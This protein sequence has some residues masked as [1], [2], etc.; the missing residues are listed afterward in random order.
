ML[1]VILLTVPVML[2]STVQVHLK[3]INFTLKVQ[4][5]V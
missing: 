4:M 5:T 2:L 3:H 1:Q